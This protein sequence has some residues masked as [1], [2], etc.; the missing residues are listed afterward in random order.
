MIH[1]QPYIL[2]IDDDPDDLEMLSTAFDE[3]GI[4]VKTF[5][6]SLSALF[7]L[8]LVSEN[9]DLPSLIIM[10]YNMPKKNGYD[11]LKILKE[12]SGTW[13]IPVLIYSTTVNPLLREKLMGAGAAGCFN[14]SVNARELTLQ[15]K[16][17]DDH[18][19]ELQE[20]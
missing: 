18:F 4:R 8:D 1:G 3:I 9:N 11:V 14:K 20:S 12:N 17:F 16:I 13:G 5:E 10:D 15:V 7:Y 2:L 6:S 19:M